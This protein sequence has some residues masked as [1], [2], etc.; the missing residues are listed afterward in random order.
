MTPVPCEVATV[1]S[2]RSERR[3]VGETGEVA[4]GVG[5][6]PH[7][8][9]FG[10]DDVELEGDVG[11]RADEDPEVTVAVPAVDD[12]DNHIEARRIEEPEAAA[13]LEQGDGAAG[14]LVTAEV[15]P[16][17]QSAYGLEVGIVYVVIAF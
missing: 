6:A 12:L 15:P 1:I 3:H 11:E 10:I 7:G 5:V 13:V 17:H 14:A 2:R 16:A 9:V 8:A 4:A